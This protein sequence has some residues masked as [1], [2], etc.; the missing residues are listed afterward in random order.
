M[1]LRTRLDN[2]CGATPLIKVSDRIYGKLE[3]YSPTGSVKDRFVTYAVRKALLRGD[4]NHDTVL[5][6][7]TSGNTGIALSAVSASLGLKCVIFMPSNMSK[8]RRHMMRIYGAQIVDA[9]P[10]DFQ[11]AIEMRNDFIAKSSNVWSPMQFSNSENVE[12]HMH[13]TGPEIEKQAGPAWSAF[14]H[15]SGTGGTIEGIRK[16]VKK[17][18]LPVSIHMVVPD[19]E[20]HGI[21]GIGDGQDFLASPDKMNSVIR[22]KTQDAVKR[23]KQFAKE[24]GILVGISAGANIVA[25]EKWVK[26]NDP[27][28]I[29]VTML[30][31]R[32]E[33]YMSIYN[34]KA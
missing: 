11:S 16:F 15:G 12:C 21:Q 28:G 18:S 19:E 32:G 30:C 4:I 27:V 31:D 17:E 6:E 13:E 2:I 3:T 26:D 24:T 29:V 1:A 33:R 23:A 14:I 9:P 5:C 22:I 10:S 34:R 8:E 20:L 7:A 25:S